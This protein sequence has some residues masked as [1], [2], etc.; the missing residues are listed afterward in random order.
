MWKGVD[1]ALKKVSKEH[2]GS[3]DELLKELE[4]MEK[5]NHVRKEI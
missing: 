2:F 1:V 5:L 3:M 4:V